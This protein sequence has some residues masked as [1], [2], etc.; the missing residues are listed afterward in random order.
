MNDN[1]YIDAGDGEGS[2]LSDCRGS[3]SGAIKKTPH[4]RWLDFGARNRLIDKGCHPFYE[5]PFD[6]A[7]ICRI[8]FYKNFSAWDS[9]LSKNIPIMDQVFT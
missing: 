7:K 5:F 4:S 2:V 1:D 3:Y 8:L 6:S 9:Y